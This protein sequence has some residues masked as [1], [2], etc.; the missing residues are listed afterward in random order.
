[1]E[2]E[3]FSVPDRFRPDPALKV[4]TFSKDFHCTAP[5]GATLSQGPFTPLG[6]PS[7][8]RRKCWRGSEGIL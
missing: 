1:M 8:Q 5:A 4:D 2:I 3:G 7:A 6:A